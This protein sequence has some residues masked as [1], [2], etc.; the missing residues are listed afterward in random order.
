MQGVLC[1]M[2]IQIQILIF[3]LSFSIHFLMLSIN[4]F[5]QKDF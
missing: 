4:D 1:F 5:T 2:M 3:H